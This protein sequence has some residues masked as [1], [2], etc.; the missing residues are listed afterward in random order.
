MLLWFISVNVFCQCSRLGV[1]WYRVI[2]ISLSRFEYDVRECSNFIGLHL[3]VQLFQY[4]LL[5]NCLLSIA[6]SCLLCCRLIEHMCVSLFPGSVT[7][8]YTSVFL[9]FF[10]NTTLWITV[11]LWYC[12][13]YGVTSSVLFF[14]LSIALAILFLLLLLFRI[15]FRIILVMWKRSWVF[16]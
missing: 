16:W 10:A 8:I 11:A 15:N 1:L 6:Y 2:F 4:H 14:S 7:L 12:L 5:K 13:K 9:C 3:A